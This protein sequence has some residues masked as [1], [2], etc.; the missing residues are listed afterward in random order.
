VRLGKD[1]KAYLN[2][3][4]E[5]IRKKVDAKLEALGVKTK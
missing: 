2:C 4:R 5:Q 3:L 1:R